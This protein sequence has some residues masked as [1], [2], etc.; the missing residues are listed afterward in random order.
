MGSGE[1]R[2]SFVSPGR[3]T[4]AGTTWTLLRHSWLSSATTSTRATFMPAGMSTVSDTI[5]RSGNPGVN[6]RI[7]FPV[8][9]TTTSRPDSVRRNRSSS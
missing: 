4:S 5:G 6:S 2:S 1:V 9:R 7:A 8:A 3:T